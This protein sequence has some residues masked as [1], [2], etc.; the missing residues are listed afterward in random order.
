MG[1]GQ[2][3][4]LKGPGRGPGSSPGSPGNPRSR[5]ACGG[6]EEVQRAD[7]TPGA[8]GHLDGWGQKSLLRWERSS[9]LG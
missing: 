1:S 7:V 8:E 5:G 3:R 2:Q 6:G 4:P 9:H